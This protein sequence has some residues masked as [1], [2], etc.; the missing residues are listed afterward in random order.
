MQE[1]SRLLVL[2]LMNCNIPDGMQ[3]KTQKRYNVGL[4]TLYN[5]ACFCGCD[6]YVKNPDGYRLACVNCGH[7]PQ[8]HEDEF[9]MSA[10]KNES[11]SQKRDVDFG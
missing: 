9:R 4:S 10:R 7:G 11:G 3:P 2:A 8:N 1:S 5:M 6:K